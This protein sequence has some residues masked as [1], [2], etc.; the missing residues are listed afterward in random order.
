[1]AGILEFQ[2]V[3]EWVEARLVD[4]GIVVDE[5]R[6]LGVPSFVE[7]WFAPSRDANRSLCYP[8]EVVDDSTD[9]SLRVGASN[10]LE[11][12]GLEPEHQRSLEIGGIGGR[13]PSMETATR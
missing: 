11:K 10:C 5:T 1:M 2:Q 13:G 4:Q 9:S 3:K 7:I 6:I 12:Y 8:V